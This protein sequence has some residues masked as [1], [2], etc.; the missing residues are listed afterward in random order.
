MIPFEA[1]EIDNWS[2]GYDSPNQFPRLIRRLILATVST[3]S[4]MKIPSGS[5]IWLPGWDGLLTVGDENPWVPRGTS[6]WEFSCAKGL[7]G[8]ATDDYQKRTSEPNGLAAADATF[9]FATPGRWADK[10]QW[11]KDRLEESPWADVRVL[12]AD[13]LVAWLEQA[14]AVAHW[15]ARLIH[16]IPPAG[17]VPLDEWWDHWS[18][19]ASPQI[20]P[21]LLTAGRQNQ[22]QRITEWF[23]GESRDYYLQGETQEEAIAFLGS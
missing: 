7:R 13:D 22:V 9:I 21:E 2:N 14:P 1:T 8:K 11:V 5:S 12:D 17:V 10:N 19:A 18:M 4:L 3:P 15:F 16:K 20:S 23:Q 6:A